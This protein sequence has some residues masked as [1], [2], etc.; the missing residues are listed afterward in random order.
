ML[1][2]DIGVATLVTTL[3]RE[4]LTGVYAAL[5]PWRDSIVEAEVF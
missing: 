1:L 2:L 3:F 4:L 5:L